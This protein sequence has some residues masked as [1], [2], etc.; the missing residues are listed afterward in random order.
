MDT[1]QKGNHMNYYALFYDVVDHFVSRRSPYRDNHLRLAQEAY[2]RGELLLAG[3]LSDPVD[4][5]LLVFHV[6][7][8]TV[9]EDFARNDPYV[10]NGLVTRW[11]VR[12]WTVVIGNESADEHPQAV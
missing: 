12:S 3:A 2:H 7:E 10:T 6:P 11:E 1:S 8:R 9:V 4:R 5:A